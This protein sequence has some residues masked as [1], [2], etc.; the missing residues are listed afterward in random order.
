MDDLPGPPG[1]P[2]L[3][4]L[5]QVRPQQFHQ[6]LESWR[7]VY[8]DTFL[9][10]LGARRYLCVADPAAI[11]AALRDRPA[12]INRTQRL[13]SNAREMGF[14][15]IIAA[16]GQ[17]WQRQRPM[18][19]AAFAPG[20]IR[21]YFPT[22]VRVT[23]RLHKRWQLAAGDARDI[24][25]S[26]DLMRF[27]VD[28]ISGLSFGADTN[29]LERDDDVIQRHLNEI[30]P[31]LTR[32]LAAP[33]PYW[34]WVKLPADRRLERALAEV[35]A[36]VRDFIAQARAR[37]AAD[38]A[39]RASPSNLIEAMLVAR[40]DPASGLSDRDV[41]GN[42]LTL[43]LAGEDTTAHT[44]AWMIYLLARHPAALQRAT[45]EARQVLG[46]ERVP[47]SFEQADS[48]PYIEA[49]CHEAMRVKPVA[50]VNVAQAG[51]DTVVAGVEIPAGC[52]LL[53]LM[54]PA[55]RDARHFAQPDV[56]DP[57][58][59]LDGGGEAGAMSSAK[60]VSMP[61]GAGPRMCPGRYLALLEMKMVLAMLLAGFD[62]EAVT[63]PDGQEAVERLA[64]T[65]APV[66]LKLRLSVRD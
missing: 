28:V 45:A 30:F 60:R 12:V 49:C 37:L 59:W 26:P 40:D 25:L 52:N 16:N 15:G 31:G 54:R 38:P 36:A 1:L 51:R 17:A 48:L 32:R 41:A 58:R 63:T 2:L 23:R 9:V 3:G 42:V 55:T 57:A 34:H 53:F 14:D 62:I 10:R 61:F 19:M 50:P 22:L 18:L 20:R 24:D 46:D 44:L 5:H 11:A 47:V 56:F 33:F 66:G 29:T 13:V 21:S 7:E 65:M 39:L 43:L 35:H 6:Q 4:N 8:G 64:M 27:T